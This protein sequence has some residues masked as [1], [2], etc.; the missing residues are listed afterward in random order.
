MKK[1][2]VM[3]LILLTLTLTACGSAS[4]GLQTATV[5]PAGSLPTVTQLI[6]G[7]F[8]LDG[9][10]TAVTAAQ[11]KELLPL[12]QVYSELLTSDTA[13][14]EE[15]DGLVAQLQ[16][17]MTTDQMQAIKDMNLTQQDVMTV[18]QEQGAGVSSAVKDTSGTTSSTG[19]GIG[20]PDGGGGMSMGAPPDGGGMAGGMSTGSQTSGT[21]NSTAT[22]AGQAQAGGGTS[23]LLEALI[24]LL[25]SKAGS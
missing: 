4:T 2:L 16:E 24:K 1:L 25:K 13:T 8:K 11:A 14:Q 12:W 19:G 18:M 23:V 22:V 15:I 3:T 10:D 6:V 5:S 17:T 21:G 20:P 9:T 7:T